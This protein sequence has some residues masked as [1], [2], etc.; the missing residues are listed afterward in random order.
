MLSLPP[1][2]FH[3]ITEH[4]Q[5]SWIKGEKNHIFATGFCFQKL[6]A[7]SSSEGSTVDVA[8]PREGEQAEMEPEEDLKPE[9]CFTEGKQALIWLN[10]ISLLSL[11]RLNIPHLKEIFQR[12]GEGIFIFVFLFSSK[13]LIYLYF[14]IIL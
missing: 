8:P 6:N 14:L 12:N 5:I 9:A 4:F 10:A 1:P 2:F 11:Q 3:T 13:K 7:T